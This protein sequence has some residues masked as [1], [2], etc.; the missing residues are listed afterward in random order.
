M[1][2]K[3]GAT[4]DYVVIL[5]EWLEP[6]TFLGFV[7]TCQLRDFAG[8]LIEQISIEWI[9]PLTTMSLALQVVDTSTWRLGPAVFDISLRRE[10]PLAIVPTSTLL[11]HIVEKVTRP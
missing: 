2:H 9:D 10:D 3:R 5:P 8:R 11:F 6:G 1:E 4:F 7:P